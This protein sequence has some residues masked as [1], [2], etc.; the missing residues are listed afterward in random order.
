MLVQRVRKP[1]F[2]VLR[3]V[4]EPLLQQTV[5]GFLVSAR[6]VGESGDGCRPGVARRVFSA[7][8]P[9]LA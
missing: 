4:D 6:I 1:A 2:M 9:Q 8:L 5:D 7:P 3:S